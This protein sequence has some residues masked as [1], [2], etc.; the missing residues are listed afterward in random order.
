MNNP[1]WPEQIRIDTTYQCFS[2]VYLIIIP[3][4]ISN[5]S[6]WMDNRVKSRVLYNNLSN[7]GVLHSNTSFEEKKKND[8]DQKS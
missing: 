2:V 7:F 5:W 3:R 8:I 1:D 4:Y 6:N